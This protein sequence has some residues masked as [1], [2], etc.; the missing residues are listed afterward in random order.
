MKAKRLIRTFFILIILISNVSCDQISKKL[1]RENIEY[2]ENI[3]VIGHFLTLT[4]IENT[5]AFLSLGNT[6]PKPVNTLLL[7]ILPLIV[8]GLTLFYLL[9]KSNLSNLVVLGICFFAGGGIGNLYDRAVYGSVTDFLHMD[10]GIFR[11]GIFNMADLS[12]M[13]G[14]FFIL[15]DGFIHRQ[16]LNLLDIET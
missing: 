8:L 1:V 4:K 2:N 7:I 12:I 9:K 6:L 11:T 16:K 14:V 15:L 3:M 13:T 5:G 10:F